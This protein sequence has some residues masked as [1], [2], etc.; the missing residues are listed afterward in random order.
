MWIQ[1]TLVVKGP[2]LKSMMSLSARSNFENKRSKS[3]STMKRVNPK[4]K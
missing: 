1:I 2:V 4:M 3:I